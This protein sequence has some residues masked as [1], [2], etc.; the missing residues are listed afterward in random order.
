MVPK[1]TQQASHSILCMPAE[2]SHNLK[3]YIL[4][5][6][7]MMAT[8]CILH[9][10][11]Q[12]WK[13][14]IKY[15]DHS[16]DRR[17][18]IMQN[19]KENLRKGLALLP[20]NEQSQGHVWASGLVYSPAIQRK[21]APVHWRGWEVPGSFSSPHPTSQRAIQGMSGLMLARKVLSY[22]LP[23]FSTNPSKHRPVSETT[24]AGRGSA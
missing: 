24:R 4:V 11:W 8:S 19:A 17:V 3:G 9:L 12:C 18:T 22:V 23:G 13:Q 7:I 14:K 20:G 2:G 10:R 16:W 1:K 21:P 5:T 15:K 6:I